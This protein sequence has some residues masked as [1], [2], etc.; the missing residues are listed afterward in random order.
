MR[1]EPRCRDCSTAYLQPACRH[2]RHPRWRPA[3]GGTWFSLSGELRIEV[4]DASGKLLA[5]SQPSAADNTKHRI[6]WQSGFDL[7]KVTGKHVRFRFHLTNGQL[8]AFWVN[9]SANGESNGY[10]GGGGPDYA[11][12]RDTDGSHQN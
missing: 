8:C 11:G 9:V 6:E 2:L 1:C 10:L 5:T 3:R 7:S 4:I 12:I